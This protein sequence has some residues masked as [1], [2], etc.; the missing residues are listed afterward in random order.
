M[1]QRMHARLLRPACCY[2]R[3]L[4]IPCFL[5][6]DAFSDHA[7]VF[8]CVSMHLKH[9]LF[10]SLS[11]FT[12]NGFV[13]AKRDQ[14]FFFRGFSQHSSDAVHA[15]MWTPVGTGLSTPRNGVIMGRP[16]LGGRPRR[17]TGHKYLRNKSSHR[18]SL[19]ADSSCEGRVSGSL[20]TSRSRGYQYQ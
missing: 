3:K 18:V 12:E 19:P 2:L 7:C 13:H 17:L 1:R 6:F 5:F 16:I 14:F 15:R 4:M 8:L 20:S 9:P 11:R 10:Q